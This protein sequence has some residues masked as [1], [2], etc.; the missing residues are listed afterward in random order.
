MLPFLMFSLPV[1][2][3]QCGTMPSKTLSQAVG[4]SSSREAVFCLL[5]AVAFAPTRTPEGR[6]A[7]ILRPRVRIK[8]SF[9]SFL[10]APKTR[11]SKSIEKAGGCDSFALV[12]ARRKWMLYPTS[13]SYLSCGLA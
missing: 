5:A 6:R 10:R 11:Q 1:V 3:P 7:E 12:V 9:W 2:G 13:D 8:L 4:I